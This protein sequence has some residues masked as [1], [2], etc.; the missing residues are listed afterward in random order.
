MKNKTKSKKSKIPKLT[1]KQGG[2]NPDQNLMDIMREAAE[3]MAMES[4]LSEDK[5]K[6]FADNHEAIVAAYLQVLSQTGLLPSSRAIS[7][8][9]G[10]SHNTVSAHLKE[11]NFDRFR[12]RLA[13]TCQIAAGRLA[14]KVTKRNPESYDVKTFFEIAGQVKTQIEHSGRVDYRTLGESVNDGKSTDERARKLAELLAS[15]Q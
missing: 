1:K 6:D 5:R 10:L 7:R 15:R 11:F 9:T 2:E 3:D 14:E 13:F 8:V 4:G 12:K